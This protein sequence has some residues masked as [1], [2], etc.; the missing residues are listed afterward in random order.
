MTKLLG[1]P[2]MPA[3][4][5]IIAILL[6]LPGLWNG[7]TLDDNCFFL[8]LKGET[9]VTAK[10][11]SPLNLFCFY[12]GDPDDGNR[13]KNIGMLMWYATAEDQI[14]AIGLYR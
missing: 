12:S 5:A 13:L 1:Q 2:W 6:S 7:F 9:K 10:A 3:V 8:I 4:A 14:A 11:S